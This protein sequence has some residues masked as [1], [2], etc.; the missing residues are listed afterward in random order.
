MSRSI[1]FRNN[2]YLDSKGITHNRS[3][4]SDILNAKGIAKR[5]GTQDSR[6]QS[7]SQWSEEK[8]T[9]LAVFSTNNSSLFQDVG[10]GGGIRVMKAGWYIIS[11]TINADFNATDASIVMLTSMGHH[12][13]VDVGQVSGMVSMNFIATA[14]YLEA[15]TKV[16]M[17]YRIDNNTN[18]YLT[19]GGRST[20]TMVAVWGGLYVKVN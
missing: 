6:I 15:N 12:Q 5:E 13:I 4:L 16:W 18:S 17:G 3:L 14:F 9:N 1:K 2:T 20:F 7:Q 8:Y 19:R 11:G 10:D